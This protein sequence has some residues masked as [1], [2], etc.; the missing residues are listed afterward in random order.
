MPYA[1]ALPVPARHVEPAAPSTP[2]LFDDLQPAAGRR[3]RGRALQVAEAAAVY[4]VDAAVPAPDVDAPRPVVKRER[5]WPADAHP[6][7]THPAD[8]HPADTHPADAHP[9]ADASAP[10]ARPAPR[11]DLIPEPCHSLLRANDSPD[12]PLAVYALAI[13]PYRGCTHG[14]TGCEVAQPGAP[15]VDPAGHTVLRVHAKTGAADRLREA[16]RRPGYVPRPIKLGSATDAYQPVERTQRLTRAVLE[17]LHEA[18]HPLAIATRSAGIVRDADLLADLA[19][20]GQL[21]VLMGL[22]TLDVAQSATLEPRASP[23][24]V[25]LAAMRTLAQAGVHVGLNLVAPQAI[26]DADTLDA[27]LAAAAKAGA[28]S[29]H[30]RGHRSEVEAGR[31]AAGSP[32]WL[33]EL[34]AR[35][36]AHGLSLSL[37]V[38]DAKPFRPPAAAPLPTT[39]AVRQKALF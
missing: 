22:A 28:R 24:A 33:A 12:L 4:R 10:E 13:N 7:D 17:V 37:P 1:A 14:C 9:V 25:R 3:R 27:L 23:P 30:V 8:T 20:Q 21:L 29:V 26:A 31:A 5:R 38:L 19:A 39:P 36:L 6:A 34:P 2:C 16:L 32:A 11:I 18:R 35:A 15:T